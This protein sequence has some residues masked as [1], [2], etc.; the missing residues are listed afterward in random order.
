M[1]DRGLSLCQE[2]GYHMMDAFIRAELALQL[3]RQ[4]LPMEAQTVLGFL[5]EPDEETWSLPEVLRIKGAIAELDGDLMGAEARY[6]D[7]LAIAERQG[8][9]TWR[10]RAA[11]SLASLWLNQGRPAEAEATLAPVYEQ[12]SSDRQW[13]DLRR[14]ADCLEDCRRALALVA[15]KQDAVL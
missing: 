15:V 12:F 11:T 10:L 14:A 5:E 8:A 3:A 9:L 4:R 6:L 7:A 2:A 1:V 13:P